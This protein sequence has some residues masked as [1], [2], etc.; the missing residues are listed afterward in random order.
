MNPTLTYPHLNSQSLNPSI[1]NP[2][3]AIREI[4]WFLMTKMKSTISK[5]HSRFVSNLLCCPKNR[6]NRKISHSQ[7]EMHQDREQKWN[8]TFCT[9][10]KIFSGMNSMIHYLD[11]DTWKKVCTSRIF[12]IRDHQWC[13]GSLDGHFIHFYFSHIANVPQSL[14]FSHS[15]KFFSYILLHTTLSARSHQ[16]R[17]CPIIFLS[18]FPFP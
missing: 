7:C 5:N 4:A 9:N 6:H 2:K 1:L 13:W 8:N 18:R 11:I 12:A 10:G 3:S 17:K 14:Y 15:S 16:H